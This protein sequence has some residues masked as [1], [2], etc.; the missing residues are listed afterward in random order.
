VVPHVSRTMDNTIETINARPGRRRRGTG[1][2]GKVAVIVDQD[3][4]EEVAQIPPKTRKY[5]REVELTVKRLGK[6]LSDPVGL[7]LFAQGH[8]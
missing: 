4:V 5:L 7:R 8:S 6:I 3:L 2:L 1:M